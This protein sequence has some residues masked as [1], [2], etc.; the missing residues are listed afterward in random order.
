MSRGRVEAM[1]KEGMGEGEAKEKD[2]EG[3]RR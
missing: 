2:R 1:R 3:R